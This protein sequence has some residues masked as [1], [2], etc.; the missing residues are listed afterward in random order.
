MSRTS[1]KFALYIATGRIIAMIA[2][3][4]MPFF[5][6]RFLSKD[7]YG[8]YAQFYTILIF[9]ST[10]LCF[11]LQSNLY[12]F[13]SQVTD[14]N[15][16]KIVWNNFILMI[17][18]G[19]VG[20]VLLLFPDIRRLLVGD[21]ELS[22]YFYLLLICVFLYIPTNLL[23]PLAVVRNDKCLA[24]FY[25]PADIAV[26]ILLVITVA[27]IWGSLYSIFCA[28]MILQFLEFLFIYG[29]ILL[30]YKNV[31]LIDTLSIPLLKE[32]LAYSLP[33]GGAVILNTLCQRFD[34]IMCISYLTVGEYAIYSLAFF[35]IPGIMQIYDSICQVNVTNMANAH[36][37]GNYDKILLLY[38]RFVIQTLSF[39]LP[40]I[41]IVLVFAPQIILF[42]FSDKYLSVIPFFRLYILTF[43][44]GMI[45][46]GTILRAVG[47]TRLSLRAFVIATVIYI[48][49]GIFLIRNFGI[50]GA[51]ISALIGNLLPK[52][53][54]VVYEQKWMGIPFTQYLP[55]AKIFKLSAVSLLLLLPVGLVAFSLEVNILTAILL[56]SIY[57]ICVY[58][59]EIRFDLFI[60]EKATVI[61]MIKTFTIK[62][63]R[64]KECGKY[65]KIGRKE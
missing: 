8:I 47:K 20:C 57:L 62:I 60:I 29:Y 55:W 53:I 38:K 33:F 63:L 39:S 46:C 34:K 23:A 44:V 12:Y 9:V 24:T 54:Q 17:I 27:E 36:K 3:F 15:K 10:I 65:Q 28:I 25:P 51:M 32:Q 1:N 11:G 49:I 41:C 13:Y 6:T 50:W 61:S 59:L 42:M 26:K 45:G 35:G 4:A 37:D 43:I 14:D 48:P 58:C 40:L 7:D 5:L 31:R 21:S 30:K 16:P 18:L 22:D 56:S 19:M 2:Q 52:M 64:I